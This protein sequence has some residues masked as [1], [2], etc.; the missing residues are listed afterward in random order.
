MKLLKI[1]LLISIVIG[2][3]IGLLRGAYTSKVRYFDVNR[4]KYYSRDSIT[5]SR[6]EI[7]SFNFY[8]FFLW[9]GI[10]SSILI[11]VILFF[12][13]RKSRS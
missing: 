5:H 1:R 6:Q 13:L 12:E 9:W 10:V 8:E 11:L 4:N 7:M 2:L 3:L